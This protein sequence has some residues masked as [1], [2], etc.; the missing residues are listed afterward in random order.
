MGSRIDNGFLGWR[1]K[2]GE[3]CVGLVC[4]SGFGGQ[5]EVLM[6][7]RLPVFGKKLKL[8]GLAAWIRFA[9]SRFMSFTT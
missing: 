3:G 1:A 6:L 7:K 8:I 2:I 9:C 5:G 4:G